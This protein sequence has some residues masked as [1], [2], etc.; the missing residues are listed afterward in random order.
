M[1]TRRKLRGAELAKRREKRRRIEVALSDALFRT[2]ARVRVNIAD[3]RI[4]L[5]VML[6][7]EGLKVVWAKGGYEREED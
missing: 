6:A 3:L 4:A 5:K 1:G 2:D 7:R